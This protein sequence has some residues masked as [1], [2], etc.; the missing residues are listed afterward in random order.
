[1]IECLTVISIRNIWVE[2][3]KEGLKYIIPEGGL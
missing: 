1:M 2:D 3:E